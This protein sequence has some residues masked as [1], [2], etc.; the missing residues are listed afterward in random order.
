MRRK[1]HERQQGALARAA[2]PNAFSSCAVV[3]ARAL[4][5]SE[6]RTLRPGRART[7][8][9]A[10]PLELRKRG[11]RFFRLQGCLRLKKRPRAVCDRTTKGPFHCD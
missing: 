1:R 11:L 10:E 9:W 4:A 5:I 2:Q 6:G 8:L 3:A 7:M